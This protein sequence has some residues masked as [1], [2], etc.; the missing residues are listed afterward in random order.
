MVKITVLLTVALV[1][2][3]LKTQKLLETSDFDSYLH[4]IDSEIESLIEPDFWTDKAFQE[5]LEDGCHAVKRLYKKNLSY[6]K[7][8]S[9]AYRND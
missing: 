5:L 1:L 8:Y 4:S 9:L 3:N 2:T 6:K 7:G